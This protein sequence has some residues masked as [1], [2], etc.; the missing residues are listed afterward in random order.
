MFVCTHVRT[1]LCMY[2]VSMYVRM[3]IGIYV[4][5]YVYRCVCVYMYM[6]VRMHV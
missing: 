4:C 1:Y 2:Y 3:C 5:A 6:Y